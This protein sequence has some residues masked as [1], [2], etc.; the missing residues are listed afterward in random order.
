MWVVLLLDPH[1]LLQAQAVARVLRRVHHRVQ[2]VVPVPLVLPA[3]PAVQEVVVGLPV[4][5]QTPPAAPVVAVTA[6]ASLPTSAK[7]APVVPIVTKW[8]V[9]VSQE[10]RSAV[11]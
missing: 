1:L 8:L 7:L 3:H 4:A 10:E 6:P 11:V 5:T 2:V 9:P